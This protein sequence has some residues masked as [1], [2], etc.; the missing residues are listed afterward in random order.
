MGLLTVTMQKGSVLMIRTVRTAASSLLIASVVLLVP[1]VAQADA[2]AP[3][4]TGVSVQNANDIAVTFTNDV[5]DVVSVDVLLFDESGKTVATNSVETTA[6][7][8]VFTAVA[9]GSGYTVQVVDHT[10]GED[11]ASQPSD[12]VAIPVVDP[13]PYS[14]GVDPSTAT[15]TLSDDGTGWIISFPSPFNAAENRT[16][17]VTTDA[18]DTC[19][20]YLDASSIDNLVSCEVQSA[21]LTQP[22]VV[23]SIDYYI[24]PDY[25][26]HEAISVD[27]GTA[28]IV[29][30]ED[31][32]GWTVSFTEPAGTSE[33]TPFVVTAQDGAGSCFVAATGVE[34]TPLSC[35][36][37]LLDD[38]SV[39][40]TL[41]SISSIQVMYYARGGVTGGGIAED[42]I[43]TTTVA[44]VS[45][46][47]SYSALP[48]RHSK[49]V[50][51][52]ATKPTA[53]HPSG[54]GMVLG[55]G[56]MLVMSLGMG[57]ARWRRQARFQ[58]LA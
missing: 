3:V 26:S 7:S 43:T 21:D 29:L 9:A 8:D 42:N 18:G 22:P 47:E 28:T 13:M 24:L 58:R 52:T 5:A 40:P 16:F 50:T 2:S 54:V 45:P 48:T 38:P 30:N 4:I 17:L 10:S 51:I 15:V 39:Q 57:W 31:G 44:G 37:N 41:T 36:L 12:S 49:G 27:P 32:S 55:F 1:A 56:A 35:D 19:N 53:G 20:A 25:G 23:T 11:V 33:G 14:F 6:T 46:I 34:G